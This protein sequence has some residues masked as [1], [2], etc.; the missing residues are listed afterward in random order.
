MCCKSWWI[1]WVHRPMSCSALQF[2]TL[3]N[4]CKGAIEDNVWYPYFAKGATGNWDVATWMEFTTRGTM[5]PSRLHR[6]RLQ[7]PWYSLSCLVLE[8]QQ[9]QCG[10]KLVIRPEQKGIIHRKDLV[11]K[12]FNPVVLVLQP[13]LAF[14]RLPIPV[15]WLRGDPIQSKQKRMSAVL[16]R[17]CPKPRGNLW[18]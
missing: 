18:F 13:L 5:W 8:D 12:L 11:H 17:L 16:M 4:M 14:C 9:S 7:V 6:F 2:K 3:Y 1:C 10:R 15:H